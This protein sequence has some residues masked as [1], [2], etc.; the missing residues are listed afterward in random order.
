MLYVNYTYYI[1]E[2]YGK[3]IKEEDF[4]GIV[5]D[6]QSF[7]FRITYGRADEEK[8]QPYVKDAICAVAEVYNVYRG[9]AGISSESVDG[10]NVNYL[11]DKDMDRRAYKAARQYLPP[12]MLYSGVRYG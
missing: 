12:R 5:R 10:Y 1:G 4:N 8:E 3:S 2:F 6:A 7:V 11:S 9:H